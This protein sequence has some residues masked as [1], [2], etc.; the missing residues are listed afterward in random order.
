VQP[1]LSWG[2]SCKQAGWQAE[3]YDSARLHLWLAG[4]GQHP[5]R[6][7]QRLLHSTLTCLLCR[8]WTLAS[9]LPCCCRRAVPVAPGAKGSPAVIPVAL[10]ELAA[11][12]SLRIYIPQ[13]LRTPVGAGSS[14][15]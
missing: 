13:D 11:F 1:S 12:S 2:A 6:L 7:L 3:V 8:C 10:E 5:T 14:V 9:P 4:F 15:H